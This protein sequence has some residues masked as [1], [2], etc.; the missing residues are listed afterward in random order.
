M[1]KIKLKWKTYPNNIPEKDGK[2]FVTYLV[3]WTGEVSRVVDEAF[4]SHKYQRWLHLWQ[5]SNLGDTFPYD[6]IAYANYEDPQ[7]EPYSGE[8]D[9]DH[10][11]CKLCNGMGKR[12]TT[13]YGI[14]KQRRCYACK[15]TGYI[16]KNDRNDNVCEATP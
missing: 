1:E 12:W 9:K 7:Y 6:I 13:E 11:R 15:G 3:D 4:Y 2:Y 14:R 16:I 5:T 10:H 8:I